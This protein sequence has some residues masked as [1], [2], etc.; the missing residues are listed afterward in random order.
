MSNTKKS[1]KP[2][3]NKNKLRVIRTSQQLMSRITVCNIHAPSP[4]DVDKKY[5]C[6]SA[7]YEHKRP[8]KVSQSLAW[9]L[10][11]IRTHWE[12]TCGVFCRNQQGIH[13][14]QYCSI[15]AVKPCV[16]SDLSDL[17]VKMCKALFDQAP[18]LHKLTP[19][20]I[21]IPKTENTKDTDLSF[22]IMTAHR[23]KTFN[24]IGTNFEISANMP[25]VDYHTGSW[26]DIPFDLSKTEYIDLDPEEVM[27]IELDTV[28]VKGSNNTSEVV[29]K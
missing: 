13:Y 28:E 15:Q 9:A 4:D 12:V 17:A 21:A 10:D 6:S 27:K 24:A 3:K 22:A 7:V 16:S 26:G 11:N 8:I 19:F 1:R 5:W 20:W 2:S 18:K 25:F 23:Y 29:T 14:M